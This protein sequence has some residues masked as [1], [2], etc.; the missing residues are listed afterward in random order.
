MTR[1]WPNHWTKPSRLA[2]CV[3]A[4]GGP[5]GCGL[6]KAPVAE[7]KP[8][9]DAS[10][11]SGESIQT[12]G[13]IS[14]AT[15]TELDDEQAPQAVDATPV[16]LLPLPPVEDVVLRGP[17]DLPRERAEEVFGEA[18]RPASPRP[19]PTVPRPGH[20]AAEL[21]LLEGPIAARVGS[22]TEP[23]PTAESESRIDP[24]AM[25]PVFSAIDPEPFDIID[26]EEHRTLAPPRIAPPSPA[27]TSSVPVPNLAEAIRGE[28][29]PGERQQSK[30][31]DSEMAAHDD[32]P[33]ERS[34]SEG[35]T[36]TPQDAP[37]SDVPS[38]VATAPADASTRPTSA[39]P[40]HLDAALDSLSAGQEELSIAETDSS[41]DGRYG[42]AEANDLADD[43]ARR[44]Q[45]AS[46]AET[47][48]LVTPTGPRF[49]PSTPA[50]RETSIP[51]ADAWQAASKAEPTTPT[52]LATTPTGSIPTLSTMA[53]PT[54][55]DSDGLI[56]DS[57]TSDDDID[58]GNTLHPVATGVPTGAKINQQAA[59][60]IRR[61]YSLAQRGAYYSARSEFVSVLRILTQGKDHLTGQPRRGRALTAGLRALD[62]VVDFAPSGGPLDADVDLSVITSSHRTPIA[63]TEGNL[64]PQQL[65]DR[66]FRYAQVQL[67]AAVAGEPAGSM[68]L[69]AL[70]KLHSQLGRVE[71]EQH[72]LATRFAYAYQQAA[73]L[74][75][76]Q[77]HL[78]AHELGVLMAESGHYHE[79]EDL[80]LQVATRE[81]HP[82]VLQ[83]LA[84]V[85]EHLGHV[86]MAAET[87]QTASQMRTRYGSA[88]GITWVD[89]SVFRSQSRPNWQGSP[90]PRVAG[91][92]Q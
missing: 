5:L 75:H 78:A 24:T 11:T 68:A 42:A 32:V 22:R 63:E 72:P 29:A 2:L 58:A 80:L 44:Q 14:S 25:I 88:N 47:G 89:P 19:L 84:R 35:L 34:F 79:A 60:K 85:Q 61:G 56:T 76:N 82:Q 50:S 26:E 18:P 77:N 55:P 7:K 91:R 46:E 38:M 20:V 30:R 54:A 28:M 37:P 64:L 36:T 66:Y 13:F 3:L 59:D 92:P 86:R 8:A 6:N 45:D 9:A 31:L 1:H 73:L 17:R 57:R 65:M 69:H 21:T 41:S 83:N 67:G 15:A 16:E 10:A 71:A 90:T 87:K 74:A 53:L 40:P 62:E 12:V 4:L 49:T 52:P 51:P 33:R 23:A 27:Q 70:G 39:A 81:P 43:A 48:K